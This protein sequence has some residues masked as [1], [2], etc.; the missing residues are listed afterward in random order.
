MRYRCFQSVETQ[1]YV[2]QSADFYRLPLDAKQCSN[3]DFQFH[4][5]LLEE[6]P[7]HRGGEY[8]SLEDA[9]S[10]HDRDFC[11]PE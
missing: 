7:F 6:D 9:I 11:D 1:K 8:D 5:L 2:V 3:L 4:E 10:A